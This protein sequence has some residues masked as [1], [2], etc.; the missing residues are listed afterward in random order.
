M[1]LLKCR[2]R[3]KSQSVSMLNLPGKMGKRVQHGAASI[4]IIEFSEDRHLIELRIRF[5]IFSY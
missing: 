2:V 3:R 4:V 5:V 1:L